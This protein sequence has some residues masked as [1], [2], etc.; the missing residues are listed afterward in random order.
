[1]TGVVKEYPLEAVTPPMI[2]YLAKLVC[3][4][5][6]VTSIHL[7]TSDSLVISLYL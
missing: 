4:L 1:V 3:S 7:L 5:S 2:A 6:S